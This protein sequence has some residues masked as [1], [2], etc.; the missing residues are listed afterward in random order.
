ME[1]SSSPPPA[2]SD[3]RRGLGKSNSGADL[4]MNGDEEAPG[5]EEEEIHAP[6][7]YLWLSI[8]SCFCPSYPINIVA[9]VFSV[10]ALNSYTQGDIEGSKRLGHTALLV[11]IAA[12]L[13]GLVLIG[14]L[15]AVHFTTVSQILPFSSQHA[16]T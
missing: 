16:R 4:Q 6:K 11:A 10:M 2:Y 9:F 5:P 1:G 14:I 13:I 15:C 8:L 3:L 7:N 12:I